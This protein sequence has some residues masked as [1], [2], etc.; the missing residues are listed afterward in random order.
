MAAKDHVEIADRQ[1][2]GFT[3]GKPV[4][5]RTGLIFWAVSVAAGII[6]NVF[7]GAVFA[8][9]DLSTERRRPAA[10]D[11]AH[12]THLIP[13]D[14]TGIGGTPCAALIAEYIRDLQRWTGHYVGSG[15]PSLAL[16]AFASAS[17]QMVERA[18]H[19]RNHA[20]RDAGVPC[21]RL[22]FTMAE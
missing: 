11:G 6:G 17:A 19:R 22:Q 5:R 15:F 1:Q 18:V 8:P 12:H 7:V 10:L 20:R 4:T 9:R 14:M 21:G 2:F 3:C 13:A 16:F